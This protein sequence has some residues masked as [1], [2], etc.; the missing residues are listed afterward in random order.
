[1]Q[2]VELLS[3]I[4]E[5]LGGNV[6]ESQLAGFIQCASWSTPCCKARP[7]ALVAREHATAFAG[8]KAILAEQPDPSPT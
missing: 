5:Q 1:M 4:E 3:Q 8:W 7:A 2:R 6:E